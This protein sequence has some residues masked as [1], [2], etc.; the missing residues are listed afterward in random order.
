MVLAVLEERRVGLILRYRSVK[1]VV[2]KGEDLGY[3]KNQTRNYLLRQ[4]HAIWKIVYEVYVIPATLDNVT[5]VSYKGIK[6][7]TK[8]ISLL[9]LLVGMCMIMLLT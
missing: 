6:A 9:L 3:W 4:D 5:N 8:L 2:F 1:L 7:S